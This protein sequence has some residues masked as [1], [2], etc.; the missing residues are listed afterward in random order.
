M[1]LV[2]GCAAREKIIGWYSTG[3]RLREADLDV[4][5]LFAGYCEVP[6]LV[7]CEISVRPAWEYQVPDFGQVL[8]RRDHGL[9][10]A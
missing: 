4:Q 5:E 8:R 7:I 3:P 6:V 9:K 10:T 1:R 2:V